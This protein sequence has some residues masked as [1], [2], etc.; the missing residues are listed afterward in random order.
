MTIAIWDL[1]SN[2]LLK[3]K[4]EKDGSIHPPMDRI[5]TVTIILCDDNLGILRRISACNQP[6]YELGTSGRGWE[7]MP[8]L[9]ALEILATA[10]LRVAHNGQDFDERAVPLVYPHWK[11]K[12]GSGIV[13]TLIW[14]RLLYPDIHRTGPNN[15]KLFPFE[16]A[17]HNL[18]SW[19][20][21][22]GEHKGDYKGGWLHWSEDMQTYGE[23][24]TIVLYKLFKWL[25]AQDPS[26]LSS[27]IEHGFAAVIRRQEWRGFCFDY[28]KALTLL[29]AL[30]TREQELEA[31]L[32]ETFG[33]WWE[34][35]KPANTR[36]GSGKDGSTFE[37]DEEEDEEVQEERRQAWLKRQ[38]FANVVI[39]GSSRKVKMVGFPDITKRRFSATTGKEIKPYV[40][41][42]LIE[43]TQ[44]HAYTPIKRVQFNPS[45]RTHVIKRLVAL[46]NWEP[47]LFT[48][49][50]KT[51]PPQPKVD[52]GVLMGL[53]Y[54][55]AQLLAEYYLVLKRIGMLATGKK[56]WLKV[57][58]EVPQ[59]NGTSEWFIH[60]RVN[61]CGALGGRCTH[62]DPNLAQVPKNS[63]GVKEYPDQWYLHG[64]AC[65]D[66]FKARSGYVLVGFDASSLELV[67]L[68][69]YLHPIDG[70]V[71]AKAVSEGRKE[72][73]TDPHS[74]MCLMIGEEI[75][76]PVSGAGRDN[77][78]TV[79]YA[80]LYGAGNEKR[81]A[82]IKPHAH[83]E[84]KIR[85]GREI[86]D[87]QAEKFPALA[88]LKAQ[89]TEAV[90]D[91]GF[92]IGLDKR[93][94]PIRKAH[95]ALNTLLQ[96]AGAVV[97]KMALILLDQK[98]QAAGLVP[99]QDYEFVANVHDEA[100]AEVLPVHVPMFKELA[101]QAVAE[102]GT[103][104]RLKCPLRAEA[105]HGP[106]WKHTH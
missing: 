43:Y 39:P 15:H 14:S 1:E 85:I 61:T 35:G 36:A 3:P 28:P 66:L 98:L 44:G 63:S 7:R 5:H 16:K 83:R 64:G 95:A 18:S 65:R 19:G 68:A 57:A 86:G 13:D 106:S 55:E 74:L 46:R 54:P 78:K 21:R 70:G 97:M 4:R 71:Y 11:P 59:P 53:P 69:H 87:R 72:D 62:S 37:E 101:I 105:A 8:I 10:D 38:E 100:Q 96:S 49:G 2:G 9:D 104:L 12:E 75:M 45:S 89:V 6:G 51:K 79:V 91:K 84:E 88:Q 42:P 24:D 34:Y 41:P 67:D 90:E 76:G 40:G 92:L 80:D 25:K 32:I 103:T 93:K 26:R 20:K 56:A 94:L 30:T 17:L 73:R 58:V 48:K 52:D 102:A 31:S 50:G 47:T 27:W 33:E 77:A 82:I 60:G 22:L 99:G 23:Q 29:G 81:G